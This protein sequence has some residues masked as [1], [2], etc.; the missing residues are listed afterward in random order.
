MFS[1]KSC[2]LPSIIALT[3]ATTVVAP[4]GAQM[5][6]YDPSNY[7]QNVLQAARALQQVNNQ[8]K[9][10]SNEA[11]MLIGMAKNLQSLD[12]NTLGRLNADL[13]A[14]TD[15]MKQAKGIAFT[16]QSTQAAF[17][18]QYPA[19]YTA[20]TSSGLV[21]EATTR[22][23]ASMDAFE[24]TLL[25]Q[26]KV[27]ESLSTDATTLS[28]LVTA[29]QGSEGG[30]QAQQAANQLQALNIKQQMQIATLLS[31]QYRAEALDLARKAQAEAAARALTK[32]FI[33]SG[34]A[35]TAH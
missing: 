20:A 3:L 18:A 9:S 25:V 7:A 1:L 35:Y 19:A 24:Q 12:L 21:N 15:L 33:G 14:I 22:W 17:K 34:S 2:L 28:D 11:T 27:N 4:A 5:A 8:I 32:A 31:A 6:V 23:Q 30:L 10:L 29:S 16:L 26:A 13:A